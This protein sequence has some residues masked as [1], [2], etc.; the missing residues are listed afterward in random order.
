M[1]ANFFSRMYC[2]SMMAS[3][4]AN[5]FPIVRASPLIARNPKSVENLFV[6]LSIH[7]RG[8]EIPSCRS[9][10]RGPWSSGVRKGVGFEAGNTARIFAHDTNAELTSVILSN[11]NQSPKVL[12]SSWDMDSTKRKSKGQWFLIWLLTWE[13]LWG[14]TAR[15][16]IETPFRPMSFWRK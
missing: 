2:K 12:N 14:V 11:C 1:G 5:N 16:H 8:S 10:S 13:W 9:L 4:Y 3:F 6:G 7:E 15:P